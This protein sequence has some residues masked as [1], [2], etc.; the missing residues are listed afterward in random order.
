MRFCALL[1][2][3]WTLFW[4]LAWAKPS[5]VASTPQPES[6]RVLLLYTE[7]HALPAIRA[8]DA[9][10][11]EAIAERGGVEIFTE[12]LDFARF[13]A[14]EHTGGLIEFIKS[15]YGSKRLDLII[16]AG[17][18]ALNFAV[19][20]RESL[21]PG[22]QIAYCGVEKEQVQSVKLPADVTGIC[23][24]YDFTRTVELA[25]KLQPNLREAVCIFGT[26]GF[27]RQ[28]GHEA[29]A[30][31][32]SQKD[33]S[34]QQWDGV[35]YTEIVERVRHLP[36]DS[37]ILFVS[38][39]RDS[40]GETHLTPE[41][42]REISTASA[43][44]VY[45]VAAHL[46]EHGL[47]GG[48]MLDYGAHGRDAGAMAVTKLD[49]KSQAHPDESLNPLQINWPAL[50]KWRIA[51]SR[52]PKEAVILFKPASLWQERRGMI[53][54]IFAVLAFQSFLIGG[55]LMNRA[56]RHRAE[57]ELAESKELMHLA[58]SAANLGM[59]VWD[60]AKDEAWMTEE[61]R[62]LFDIPAATRIDYDAILQQVHPEDR[63]LREAAIQKAIETR[64][65]Y[66][67]EYRILQSNGDI[68]WLIARGRCISKEHG[69]ELKIFGVSMD[70]TARKKAERDALDQREELG[71]LTRVALLGEMATSLAHELNQP[72]TAIVAN[73]SAAQRF[74]ANNAMD[75][76]ELRDILADIAASGLRA[77]KIIRGIKDMVGKAV[78]DRAALDVN[79]VIEDTLRLMRTDALTIECT[80]STELTTP[81]PLV[82]GSA[83]QLQQVLLN[84][85]INALDVMRVHRGPLCKIEI[86]SLLFS[87]QLIEVSVRDYGPGL[88]PDAPQK[89]FQR[90]YSTKK[91]G[92]G[93][94]LSIARSIVEAHNGTLEASNA[95]GGGACFRFRLPVQATAG[96]DASS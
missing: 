71:H 17:W 59:W 84:L 12:Y 15:R 85:I 14:D 49:A 55:L 37:M 64:G 9:G 13:P 52:V 11:T 65:A 70:V 31:L 79:D 88:P 18:E 63:S 78:G 36:P 89:V 92:M 40:A 29:L 77:G 44:P 93:M 83:V 86:R 73:A 67:M 43:V 91:D 4:S 56:T 50:K 45:G 20:Q 6:K 22:V 42:V 33:L 27:D 87:P 26:S 23:L 47:L 35:E 5:A 60:V 16:S 48:A 54:G 62:G 32:K 57:K 90:F 46:L 68:R 28:V 24:N 39:L 82:V 25:R 76:E 2:L 51:E 41:V 34:V 8:I 75:P 81:L 30:A 96:A 58:A 66:E 10:I 94:G 72:L 7:R 38:M 21:F 80:L 53:I 74:I 19:V 69:K 61:G 95:D 1:S 3:L